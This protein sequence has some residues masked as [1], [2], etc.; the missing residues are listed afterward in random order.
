MEPEPQPEHAT[1]P[2][3]RAQDDVLRPRDRVW[4]HAVWEALL[5]AAVVLA[6]LAVR[7]RD[8][9]ALSGDN[10]R[11][12][13]VSLAVGVLLGTAFALSLRAAVPN[14]A[15]GTAAVTAGALTGWLVADR[16]YSLL[17]AAMVT[18][19]ASVA[20]GLGLA[21]VVIGF[22]APAW[23]AGL[24][25]ALGLYAAVLAL[26]DGRSLLIHDAPDVRRWAWPVL[27][28]ALLLSVGGGV[29]GLL[30]GVRN[31]VG[32]YRPDG[33]PAAGRGASAAFVAACALVGSTVLAAT[34]GLLLSVRLGAVVADDGLTLLAQAAGAALLGGASAHGRRGGV[35]GT[36][37]AAALLQLSAVWL[38]L[39]EARSWARPAVLGAAIVLGLLV[40]RLVEAAG[41]R[42][43]DQPEDFH[44]IPD[45]P[46]P[47]ATETYPR[48]QPGGYNQGSTYRAD[49]DVWWNQASAN[50]PSRS[51]SEAP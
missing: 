31:G 19:G 33:D 11:S 18:L 22:R 14:L 7:S 50:S 35:V 8:V 36:A 37:L 42:R 26:T 39:V 34:A 44:P 32:R 17:T 3:R 23:A 9:G 6:V 21:V 4:V 38:G 46:D 29:L 13:L 10:L 28:G 15:V 43:G 16:G 20:L 40:G 51:A 30:P 1:A 12:V 45:E 5:A 49:G 47:Y 41:S 24:G 48:Y 2:Y 25:A 27:G